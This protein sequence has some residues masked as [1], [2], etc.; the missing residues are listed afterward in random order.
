M[1]LRKVSRI[2]SQTANSVTCTT[3]PKLRVTKKRSLT[4]NTR[5]RKCICFPVERGV[6]EFPTIW[7]ELRHKR[8][9]CD[10]TVKCND[11]MEFKVHR[12][13]LSAISPYF[14]A[15]FTNSLNRNVPELTELNIDIGN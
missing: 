4:S 10:G 7:N 1:R 15:L 5:V 12:A 11:N 14:K 6:I 3:K 9:L 8:Q 2:R 13:I